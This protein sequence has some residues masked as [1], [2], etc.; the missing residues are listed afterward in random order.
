MICCG[1]HSID[2]EIQTTKSQIYSLEPMPEE[3]GI[4][5]V[6]EKEGILIAG[7]PVRT[8]ITARKR[9]LRFRN[10]LKSFKV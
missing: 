7:S 4:K 1:L 5:A 2:L 10:N 9:Q 8:L 3:E 6:D